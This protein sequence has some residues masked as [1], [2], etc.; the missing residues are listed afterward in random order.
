[1]N[2]FDKLD[3]WDEKNEV[4]SKVF[5][6]LFLSAGA[7]AIALELLEVFGLE[8]WLKK[9]HFIT[10][11]KLIVGIMVGLLILLIIYA[12]IAYVYKEKKKKREL[13][14]HFA[15]QL[16]FPGSP[17]QTTPIKKQKQR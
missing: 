9:H 14:K 12:M 16:N 11:G 15:D 6:T 5:G 4:F 17:V 13:E 1:M 7:I 8:D 10:V 2:W 3:N